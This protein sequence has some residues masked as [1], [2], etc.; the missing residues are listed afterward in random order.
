MN[1]PNYILWQTD[2]NAFP[3]KG[4]IHEKILFLCKFG[5]LAPSIHNSQPWNY[6]CTSNVLRI[7]VD[8]KRQLKSADPNNE[9][10]MIALGAFVENVHIAAG[11]FGLSSK[12][13]I[14][15]NEIALYFS[16][17]APNS[18]VDV[19]VI[20]RRRSYKKV[21]TK[22]LID[23]QIID[24]ICSYSDGDIVVSVV[25]GAEI[26]NLSKIYLSAARKTASDPKF[27]VELSNWLRS[28]VTKKNDGM[29]GFISDISLPLSLIGGILLSRK[30]SLFQKNFKHEEELINSTPAFVVVSTRKRTFN[31]L[32]ICGRIIQRT[33]LK[34]VQADIV[35]HPISSIM[36]QPSEQLQLTDLLKLAG[37]PIFMMRI[38]YPSDKSILH[39]PRGSRYAA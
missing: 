5:V 36:H 9:G 19:D 37:E 8:E 35:A 23:K 24:N 32:V 1:R 22:K 11:R 26:R 29:P 7:K 21:F 16:E 20:K 2:E 27:V 31:D 4:L 10:A 39:T 3:S 30:P 38:G 14:G 6:S 18:S 13:K 28:N 17:S 15:N 25:H 34:I 33:W 12:V